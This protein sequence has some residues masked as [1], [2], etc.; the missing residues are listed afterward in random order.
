MAAITSTGTPNWL[1]RE[2]LPNEHGTV[3]STTAP[4]EPGRRLGVY[5]GSSTGFNPVYAEAA[6]EVGRALADGGHTLIYGGGRVGLMG[7]VADA[8]L[9]NGGDIIGVMT[10]QLVSLEVA[11]QGLTRLEV[12]PTMHARKAAMVEQSDGVVV[13]PG[14]YGT[15]DETFEVLTWNTL[16][17]VATPV[18][19]LNVD[20]YFSHLLQF[21]TAATAAGFIKPHHQQLVQGTDHPAEAV[22]MGLRPPPAYQPK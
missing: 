12:H 21:I 9:D 4:T 19:L 11:H 22:R 17:I 6:A 5:C 20:N 8:A 13:L 3:T 7:I 1:A 16:G 2:P 18:V 10:T 14:G 15:L